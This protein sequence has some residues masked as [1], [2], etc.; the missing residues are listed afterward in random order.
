MSKPRTKNGKAF[1]Q[2]WGYDKN[3][4]LAE[5]FRPIWFFLQKHSEI[6]VLPSAFTKTDVI[7]Q[8]RHRFNAFLPF[9][10][11]R[12]WLKLTMPKKFGCRRKGENIWGKLCSR[13]QMVYIPTFLGSCWLKSLPCQRIGGTTKISSFDFSPKPFGF[14]WL[15]LLKIFPFPSSFHDIVGKFFFKRL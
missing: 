4:K 13:R 3:K 6:F 15:N 11:S 9:L 1:T 2:N 8:V 14:S 5:I 10:G 12:P 7:P